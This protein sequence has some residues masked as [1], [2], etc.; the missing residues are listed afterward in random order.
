MQKPA[1][2]EKVEGGTVVE[3][4]IPSRLDRL[5]FGRF[6][7]LVIAALGI[8][9]I[10]DG[11]EVTLVSS[12][13]GAL[14]SSPTLQFTNTDVGITNSAYLAGAVLGGLF[15]GWLTDRLG[16]KKLFF[17]TLTTY[18]I[19]TLATAFSWNLL[20]FSLFRFLT[21]AGIGG[22]Y[23]AVN[24]TIQELV[25]AR[26][27]GWTDLSVNGS[28]WLGA[29]LGA[30]GSVVLLNTALVPAD[31]GWRLTFLIG[32]GLSAFI[33]LLRL[34]IP[35][36]P[37]WLITHGLPKKADK[38]VDGIEARFENDNHVLDN[39][40]LKTT[41][42]KTRSHTPLIEV[43]TSILK[44]HLDRA[45]V[46]FSLMTAQAYFYNAIFFTYALVLSSFYGVATDK[47]GWYL[48]PFAAG[49][50]LGPLLLG[51]LFDIWGRRPMLIMTYSVA[52]VLLALTGYLF[53]ADLVSESALTFAW[54]IV[55]FFGS[56]ASSAAYLTVSESFPLE[57][58]ALA[59][60]FFYAV[61][62]GVGGVIGP[63]FLAHLI[64]TGSRNSVFVGYLIGAGLMLLA[65]GVAAFKAVAAERKPLEQVA[66]PLSLADE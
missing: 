21:G 3:T 15:F 43:A 39:T 48:L 33:F 14:K 42:L 38:I 59:I 17:I 63:A 37:R 58:R 65:A 47:I 1:A 50:F 55:F 13:A 40:A 53:A 19:A 7:V 45:I 10:L 64:D 52:G 27:R 46:G 54:V 66:R 51:R 28:F 32:G 34:W 41:R 56:A 22:E 49:N 62:T 31:I 26:Y 44:T 16:R 36:S 6:H 25:P 61:G 29:A 11:L 23:T 18:M 9:W 60:S 4:T 12:I 57:V 5:P 8:T 24:S 35:E 20:S 2:S 30:L